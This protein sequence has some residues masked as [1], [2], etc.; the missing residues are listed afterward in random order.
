MYCPSVAKGSRLA[1]ERGFHKRKDAV[2]AICRLL[3]NAKRDNQG[4]LCVYRY[5]C[6]LTSSLPLDASEIDEPSDPNLVRLTP[7]CTFFAKDFR[8]VARQYFNIKAKRDDDALQQFVD[9]R[10]Q[11]TL[12]RLAV[13]F[14]LVECLTLIDIFWHS[15]AKRLF[16][17]NRI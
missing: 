10:T 5:L 13:C 17:G 15:S 6:R 2:A 11:L 9:D 12:E 7:S 4:E 14:Y 3:P 8:D 16:C 1:K